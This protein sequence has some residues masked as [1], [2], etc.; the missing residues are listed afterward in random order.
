MKINPDGTIITLHQSDIETWHTCPEQMRL[1]HMT[2]NRDETDA[3]TVGTVLHAVIE[4]EV[5]GEFGKTVKSLKGWAANHFLETL[6]GY[7]ESASAYSR[8]SFKTDTK[9]L[10]VLDGL[11]Q[12]WWDSPERDTLKYVPR[13]AMLVEWNF[14]VPF[15]QIDDVS[16]RLAGTSDL[17]LLGFNQIWDWKSAGRSYDRWEKQRWA[18]QPTVYTYAAAVEGLIAPDKDGRYEFHNKVFVRG[19]A[20]PPQDVTVFR[21]KQNWWWL[22]KQVQSML[23]VMGALPEGPWPLNDHGALCG[24][25]WCPFWSQCKG[26]LVDGETWV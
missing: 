14:D 19:N 10:A 6:E 20:G 12:A 18:I 22:E 23:A 3:A 15:M 2:S 24:P 11:V 13:D 7:A 8:S 21:S 26:S 9:A 5:T 17:V 1:T 4:H 25:K 16:I